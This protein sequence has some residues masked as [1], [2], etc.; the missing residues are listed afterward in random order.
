MEQFVEDLR[1]K[2]HPRPSLR[3]KRIQGAAGVWELTFAPDG[4]A[5]FNYGP[6]VIEGEPHVQ[7]RRIGTHDIFN[8][9]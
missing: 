6:E 4:R 2:R 5:T 3:V 1:A 9:P 7:W 8:R